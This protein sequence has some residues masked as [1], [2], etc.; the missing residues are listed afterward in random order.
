MWWIDGIEDKISTTSFDAL[1]KII[2]IKNSFSRHTTSIANINFLFSCLHTILKLQFLPKIKE[3]NVRKNKWSMKK[4]NEIWKNWK[5]NSD[6]WTK[7]LILEQCVYFYNQ[8]DKIQW[9]RLND[10]SKSL[11]SIFNSFSLLWRI[12]NFSLKIHL[13]YDAHELMRDEGHEIN[14][15]IDWKT[16]WEA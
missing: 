10:T 4:K 7:K 1:S 11:K 2:V 9:R 13:N 12:F 3:K 16:W 5:I 14:G 8:T 6:F 15:R